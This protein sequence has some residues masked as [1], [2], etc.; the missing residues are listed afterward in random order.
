MSANYMLA[1]TEIMDGWTIFSKV[2]PE[3]EE[4]LFFVFCFL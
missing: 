2:K 4:V 1:T 3:D